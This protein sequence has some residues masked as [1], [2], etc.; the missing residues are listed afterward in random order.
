MN[1][2]DIAIPEKFFP[3]WYGRLVF[4]HKTLQQSMHITRHIDHERYFMMFFDFD[5]MTL[6]VVKESV[7]K[8]DLFHC[9]CVMAPE[10]FQP[11]SFTLTAMK[12]GHATG[13]SHPEYSNV[14]NVSR[15]MSYQ[16]GPDG[17]PLRSF[18]VAVLTDIPDGW[19]AK[20]EQ[21]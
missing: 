15:E 13:G 17:E 18:D 3:N 20:Y 11:D 8:R 10:L 19:L 1:K 7:H 5:N 21:I 9:F 4:T 2:T 14:A 16:Y 12:A 6:T